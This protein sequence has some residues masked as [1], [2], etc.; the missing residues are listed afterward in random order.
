MSVRGRFSLILA[1]FLTAHIL[2]AGVAWG[3]IGVST[4]GVDIRV[5][6]GETKTGTFV[7]T[8]G[9]DFET[10]VVLEVV[11]FDRDV[12]GAVE[13]YPANSTARSLA[14]YLSIPFT[15]LTIPAGVGNTREVQFTIDLSSNASGAHWSMIFV[16]EVVVPGDSE[17][18]GNGGSY[19][20]GELSLQFGIQIR[21]E[22]P[23]TATSDGRITNVDVQMSSDGRAE[24][25]LI[26]YENLG[27][28]FQKPSGEVR[29]V[30]SSGDVVVSIPI[31]EFSMLP[32]RSR[33]LMVPIGLNLPPG[34][35]VAL[36][37][38]DFGGDFLLA[39]QSRFRVA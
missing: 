31:R 25:V 32:S 30:N 27:T 4:L 35:Y 24:G 26:D 29:I 11:D 7:I 38:L 23:T 10:F 3:S 14:N 22:D 12:T 13:T 1:V 17:E 5:A 16:R 15:E 20:Q 9:N 6:P 28:T 33:Q 18:P 39:G 34:D 21:Q 36:A 2:L 37:I 19:A 8:N